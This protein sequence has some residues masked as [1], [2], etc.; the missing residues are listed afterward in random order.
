[1]RPER[2]GELYKTRTIEPNES[3][4]VVLTISARWPDG[5]S[6][7][8]TVPAA[9]I[10]GTGSYHAPL[11]GNSLLSRIHILLRRP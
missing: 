5:V 2:P 8:I 4:D 3:F 10:W 9:E 1:M 11:E 6:R 7:E